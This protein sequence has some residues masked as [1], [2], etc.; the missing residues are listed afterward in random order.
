MSFAYA[1][2]SKAASVTP[3]HFPFGPK[4]LK[5]AVAALKAPT[6]QRF[7]IVT[8]CVPGKT[9]GC[10]HT[11]S[12]K[13]NFILLWLPSKSSCG[14]GKKGGKL[15]GH[16][17]REGGTSGPHFPLH[18]PGRTSGS[19]PQARG[20]DRLPL[21]SSS[22]SHAHVVASRK[23]LGNLRTCRYLGTWISD[24]PFPWG[25]CERRNPSSGTLGPGALNSGPGPGP[26]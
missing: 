26:V 22:D 13:I 2:V 9:E 17:K 18:P 12:T 14:E 6:R 23:S 21:K 20:R 11:H 25:F 3:M 24:I 5:A 10:K 16:G 1:G 4:L 8:C 19:A 7:C 15:G